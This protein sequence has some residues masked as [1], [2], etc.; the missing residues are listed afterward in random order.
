VCGNRCDSNTTDDCCD[1]GV[2]YDWREPLKKTTSILLTLDE[3]NLGL[4]LIDHIAGNILYKLAP[5]DTHLRQK[6]INAKSVLT[7]HEKT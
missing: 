1:C 5:D 3:I 4:S 6:L 2:V 7:E